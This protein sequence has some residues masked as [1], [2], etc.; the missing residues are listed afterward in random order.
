MVIVE[1]ALKTLETI[2]SLVRPLLEFSRQPL[3]TITL[4]ATLTDSFLDFSASQG[5][6]LRSI[7]LTAGCEWCLCAGQWKEALDAAS[8]NRDL[9]KDVVPKAHLHATH[10][11]ALD[12]VS[13]DDLKAHSAAPEAG[14][15][16]GRP[17][18][19]ESRNGGRVGETGTKTTT[20][21]ANKDQMTSREL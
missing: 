13:L 17:D 9:P 5:N 3:L 15:A 6:N 2:L 4:T 7:G 21:L 18:S 8:K 20:E 12:S 14:A 11:K 19:S 1:W 10:E 16:S